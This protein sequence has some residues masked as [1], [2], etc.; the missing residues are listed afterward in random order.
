MKA[1]VNHAA[2]CLQRLSVSWRFRTSLLQRGETL[3]EFL[4]SLE[5]NCNIF[6]H[7]FDYSKSFGTSATNVATVH[8]STRRAARGDKITQRRQPQRTP[9]PDLQE[10]KA[11]RSWLPDLRLFLSEFLPFEE[12][13]WRTPKPS[14]MIEEQPLYRSGGGRASRA[15]LREA[16]SHTTCYYPATRTS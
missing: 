4:R 9:R 16:T 12:C 7:R 8:A 11:I 14:P 5:A 1:L 13:T 6:H 10:S 2:V 15:T 3:G